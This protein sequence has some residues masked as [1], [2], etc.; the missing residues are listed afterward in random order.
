[1]E[2]RRGQETEGQKRIKA[3]R[4]VGDKEEI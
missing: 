1:V 2:Y 4:V 3:E